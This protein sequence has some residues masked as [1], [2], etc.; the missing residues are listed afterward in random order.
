MTQHS[1]AVSINNVDCLQCY[2]I[3]TFYLTSSVHHSL[4]TCLWHKVSHSTIYLQRSETG[5]GNDKQHLLCKKRPAF[6]EFIACSYYMTPN[7]NAVILTYIV[8]TRSRVSFNFLRL[9]FKTF[10]FNGGGC[11]TL[12]SAKQKHKHFNYKQP[13][14]INHN[15]FHYYVIQTNVLNQ[16]WQE[17]SCIKILKYITFQYIF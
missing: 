13:C 9:S 2:Y 6:W 1:S 3:D 11:S 14:C 10:S 17:T 16:L 4:S 5:A 7:L 8:I 15:L 12:Y